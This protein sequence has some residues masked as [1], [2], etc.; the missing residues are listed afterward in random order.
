MTPPYLIAVAGPS[1]GGKTTLAR[2]LQTILPGQVTLLSLDLYYRDLSHLTADQR[3]AVNFDAPDALDPQRLI[4]DLETL[5]QGHW[6]EVP[7]YDFNTHTRTT[8]GTTVSAGDFLIIEGIFALYWEAVRRLC[9]TKVFITASDTICLERRI[10]RDVRER[11]RTPKSVRRQYAQTVYPMYEKHIYPTLRYAD[12]TL[13]GEASTQ[14]AAAAVLAH[15]NT[16]P[17]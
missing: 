10:V 9:P 11:G 17:N 3:Q 6:V 14:Q 5:A 16:L 8:Q 2:S 15:I 1:G 4:A 12:L 7:V 13:D